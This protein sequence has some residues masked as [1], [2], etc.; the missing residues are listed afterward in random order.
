MPRS[1]SRQP[2][3]AA[4]KMPGRRWAGAKAVGS[5][6]AR[7]DPDHNACHQHHRAGQKSGCEQAAEQNSATR[8]PAGSARPRPVPPVHLWPGCWWH[9]QR[10]PPLPDLRGILCRAMARGLCAGRGRGQLFRQRGSAPPSGKLCSNKAVPVINAVRIALVRAVFWPY[11]AA[12]S[13]SS[14]SRRPSN[15]AVSIPKANSVTIAPPTGK[16]LQI[17]AVKFQCFG[18]Q[19]R[20]RR[21]KHHATGEACTGGK[22]SFAGFCQRGQCAAQTC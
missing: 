15:P 5:S 1:M 7:S 22:H 4:P 18:H 8:A 19:I 13:V 2:A 21:G 3:A 9:R 14:G 20:Q 12:S 10:A 11:F 6:W 16:R 17:A